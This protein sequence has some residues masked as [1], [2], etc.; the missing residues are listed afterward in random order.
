MILALRSDPESEEPRNENHLSRRSNRI[1][2]AS[3]LS[4]GCSAVVAVEVSTGHQAARTTLNFV[5]V[6]GLARAIGRDRGESNQFRLLW[7]ALERHIEL[8]GSA[9]RV[10]VPL[11][12]TIGYCIVALA[13]SQ[14]LSV[15]YEPT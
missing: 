14:S 3:S 6:F 9:E 11:P 13:L 15:A 2:A 7:S 8:S 12:S 1:A 4:S 5:E 10:I